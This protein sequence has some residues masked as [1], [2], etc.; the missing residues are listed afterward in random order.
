L[1]PGGFVAWLAAGLLAGWLAGK[2]LP[3]GGSGAFFNVALGLVGALAAGCVCS[4]LLR[5]DPSVGGDTGFWSSLGVAFVGAG[6]LVA[7]GRHLG[8]RVKF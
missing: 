7:V 3:G 1:H 6:V 2:V 8:S 5:S 4:L